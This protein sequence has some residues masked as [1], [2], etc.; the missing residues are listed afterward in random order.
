[1]RDCGGAALSSKPS[2]EPGVLMTSGSAP[3]YF[4]N[5]ARL[6]PA[7]DT[8]ADPRAHGTNRLGTSAET[9]SLRHRVKE[10]SS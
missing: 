4:V 8:V 5:S 1:M 9:A 2:T 3:E 6:R 7:S 10:P